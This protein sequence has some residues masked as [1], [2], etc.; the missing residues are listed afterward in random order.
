MRTAR[1]SRP[2]TVKVSGTARI[3]SILTAK[4]VVAPLSWVAKTATPEL[5]SVTGAVGASIAGARLS[6]AV[7][8]SRTARLSAAVTAKGDEPYVHQP[9]ARA[10][11]T[12][13]IHASASI[14]AGV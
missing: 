10:P 5:S 13:A 7:V 12:I 2:G 6:S 4:T 1:R 3:G 14:S 8:T 11:L 9:S